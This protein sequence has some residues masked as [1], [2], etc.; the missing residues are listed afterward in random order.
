MRIALTASTPH[1][2][3]AAAKASLQQLAFG[4][5]HSVGA[6]RRLAEQHRETLLAAEEGLGAL[7]STETGS[8][9]PS[10][11]AAIHDGGAIK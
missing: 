2:P 11:P 10:G 9:G 1:C 3:V 5:L 8:P 4:L 6:L 7:G